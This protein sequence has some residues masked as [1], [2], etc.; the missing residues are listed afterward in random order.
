VRRARALRLALVLFLGLTLAGLPGAAL[1]I[2]ALTGERPAGPGVRLLAAHRAPQDV[3]VLEGLGRVVVLAEEDHAI[4]RI[5]PETG[6]IETSLSSE[7]ALAPSRAAFDAASGRL[8]VAGRLRG[9]G[10][11]LG[12]S[13]VALGAGDL[14]IERWLDLPG[15][16]GARDIAISPATREVVAVCGRQHMVFFWDADSLERTRV[17]ELPGQL[18][19]GYDLE[20]SGREL[21]VSS[22]VWPF[23][24]RLTPDADSPRT[25]TWTPQRLRSMALRLAADPSTGRLYAAFPLERSIGVLEHGRGEPVPWVRPAGRV[26]DLALAPEAG[27]IFAASFLDGTVEQFATATGDRLGTW[28]VGP[29][30]AAVSWDPASRRLYTASA[31]G[32]YRIDVP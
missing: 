26:T 31:D 28:Q 19:A 11:A 21:V 29:R 15:C 23:L 4:D 10:G 7:A 25:G 32:V 18:F 8:F 13:V 17:A 5:D 14:S 16:Q 1:R 12:A 9:A 24:D 27:W 3:V 30:L 2:A 20:V 6:A 22:L